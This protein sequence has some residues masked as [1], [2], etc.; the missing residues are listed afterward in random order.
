MVV[1]NW[2]KICT[3]RTGKQSLEG[4]PIN[5][6]VRMNDLDPYDLKYGKVH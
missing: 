4:L 3:L 1:S 2:Q 5:S 6:V